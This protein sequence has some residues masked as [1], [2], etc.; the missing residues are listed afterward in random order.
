MIEDL[1]D[2]YVKL[3]DR[4]AVMKAEYEASIAKID[5]AMTK[6]ENYILGHLNTNGIDSVG[7]PAGTAFKQTMTSA[8]VRDWDELLPYIKSHEAWN[9]LDHRVNK[10]AVVE[11]KE[12]NN[13]LPP[14]VNWREETVVRIRRAST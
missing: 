12:A 6:V 10:T 4:K 8:T 1:I 14:G 5:E 11:F 2:R 13:D 3:R 7:S 9:L